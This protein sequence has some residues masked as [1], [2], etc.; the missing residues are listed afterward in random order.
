M[1]FC[2]L[3]YSFD[4]TP[5]QQGDSWQLLKPQIVTSTRDHLA[6]MTDLKAWVRDYNPSAAAYNYIST[7]LSLISLC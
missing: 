5:L 6:G 4:C 1:R 2:R 3:F 7:L